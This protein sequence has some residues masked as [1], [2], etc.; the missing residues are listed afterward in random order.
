MAR[1][2]RLTTA[3]LGTIRSYGDAHDYLAVLLDENNLS[4]VVEYPAGYNSAFIN[5]F[6]AARALCM[7][8]YS[9]TMLP[10]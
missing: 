1:N 5:F 2:I 3:S 10:Y 6:A 7:A 8:G 9:V 4:L